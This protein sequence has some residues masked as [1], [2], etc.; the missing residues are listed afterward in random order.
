MSQQVKSFLSWSN[1]FRFQCIYSLCSRL[2]DY[3]WIRFDWQEFGNRSCLPTNCNQIL[4]EIKLNPNWSLGKCNKVTKVYWLYIYIYIALFW[5][6]QSLTHIHTALLLAALF[7]FIP[8]I[9]CR[10]R[11]QGKFWGLVSYHT[12][13]CGQEVPGIKPPTSWKSYWNLQIR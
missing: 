5:S 3:G 2:C 11:L 4:S 12:W 6:Y 9:H 7:F 1:N 10:Q 13:A 8:F